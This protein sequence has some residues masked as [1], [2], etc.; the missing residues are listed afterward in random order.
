MNT[1]ATGQTKWNRNTLTSYGE[2]SRITVNSTFLC[3][4]A[5]KTN[6]KTLHELQSFQFR[7]ALFRVTAKTAIFQDILLCLRPDNKTLDYDVCIT[8]QS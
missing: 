3:H 2:R 4:G 5:Y 7:I 6:G 8:G 1:L